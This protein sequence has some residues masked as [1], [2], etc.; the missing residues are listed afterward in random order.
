MSQYIHTRSHYDLSGSAA[1]EAALQAKRAF[2]SAQLQAGR[3][4]MTSQWRQM[5][6][7]AMQ[8]GDFQKPT[9]TK[10]ADGKV[11]VP[12]ES[13]LTDWNRQAARALRP[14]MRALRNVPMPSFIDKSK[15]ENRPLDFLLDVFDPVFDRF[16]AACNRTQRRHIPRG[17]VQWFGK[18]IDLRIN[19]PGDEK[20]DVST[21]GFMR[22]MRIIQ[23]FILLFFNKPV[24]LAGE[25]LKEGIDIVGDVGK[26]VG[27]AV[28]K[29]LRD[30]GKTAQ[31][32]AEEAEKAVA[33]VIDWVKSLAGLGGYG[34]GLGEPVTA[35]S[36]AAAGGTTA[37]GGIAVEQVIQQIIEKIMQALSEKVP[38]I[39]V[40]LAQTAAQ[41]GIESAFAAPPTATEVAAVTPA[42]S[43][44]PAQLIVTTPGAAPS[45]PSTPSGLPSYAVPLGIAAVAAL[46][47][48]YLALRK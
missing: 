32:A 43:A 30:V 45:T 34:I 26:T 27:D 6:V 11:S 33:G 9:A 41:K 12:I 47:I 4:Y 3:D 39:A 42:A 35:A 44:A 48:G 38:E 19:Q 40:N 46:G 2:T 29:T 36:G 16:E 24:E 20:M 31:N 8:A 17:K 23:A 13:F 14:I 18:T 5:G 37:V 28:D 22:K 15:L 10:R 7:A 21:R 1:L 25:C